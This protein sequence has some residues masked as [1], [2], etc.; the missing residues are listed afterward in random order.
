MK[1]SK[2]FIKQLKR[3]WK[4]TKKFVQKK[5][6]LYIL[7]GV[8][9]LLTISTILLLNSNLVPNSDIKE[10]KEGEMGIFSNSNPSFDVLFGKKDMNL[11]N[12][13]GLRVKLRS[14]IALIRITKQK[15]KIS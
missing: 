6:T 3:F 1:K 14:L 10:T 13:L 4:K 2:E 15:R 7:F 8:S 5:T 11:L 12:G 9:F